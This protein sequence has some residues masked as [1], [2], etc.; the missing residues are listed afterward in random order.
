VA[1]DEAAIQAIATA[2]QDHA[3][4]EN[5]SEITLERVLSS[6]ADEAKLC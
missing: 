1:R 2:S 5:T 6:G 3:E 4:R